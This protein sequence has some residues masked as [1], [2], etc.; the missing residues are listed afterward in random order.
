MLQIVSSSSSRI[1]WWMMLGALLAGLAWLVSSMI[2]LAAP[3]KQSLSSGAY[4][5]VWVGTLGGLVGLY[6]LQSR[7]YIWLAATSFF[8]AFT[9]DILVFAGTVLSLLSTGQVLLAQF[10]DQALGIGLSLTLFGFALFGVGFTLLGV[11]SL[12]G[13]VIPVWCG[14]AIV[15]SPLFGWLLGAYGGIVLGIAWLG[16]SYALWLARDETLLQ[17]DH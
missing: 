14:V 1:R 8:A 5:L 4:L 10:Q 17:A 15:V 13:K 2:D 9:G 11:S 12:L 3:L 7:S 6:R 16:V